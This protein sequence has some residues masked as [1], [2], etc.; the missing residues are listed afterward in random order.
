MDRHTA[1]VIVA[2]F[3]E[4]DGKL[5]VIRE[6]PADLPPDHKPVMNQPA[7]H[8]EMGESVE[9]AVVRDVREETGYH[10]R[11]VELVGIHQVHTVAEGST[12]FAFLFRCELVDEVQHAITATEIVETLWLTQEEILARQ[13]EHR[14]KTT[15]SRFQSY[16]SGS[17]YP[18][19]VLTQITT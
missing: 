10:V 12:T 7:G 15:T 5:L 18:L 19:E 8:V 11:P 3:V 4:R 1:R 9:T 2:G 6:R 16:F 14:T 13:A 17:R